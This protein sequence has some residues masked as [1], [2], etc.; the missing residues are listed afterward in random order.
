MNNNVGKEGNNM[1]N[2]MN[3]GGGKKGQQQHQ[4]GNMHAPGVQESSSASE[5]LLKEHNIHCERN[6]YKFTT[7]FHLFNVFIPCVS[8]RCL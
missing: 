4:K 2:K 3:K 1:N 8:H 6:F 5:L 7:I